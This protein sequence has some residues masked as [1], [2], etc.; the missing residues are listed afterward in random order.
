MRGIS[1][2][3]VALLGLLPSLSVQS[4]IGSR[5]LSNAKYPTRKLGGIE[6]IDT[7]IVREAAAFARLHSTDFVYNH[8]IRGWL[9]GV[10]VLNHNHTLKATVDIE[11][12]AVACLLHDL[13]WDQTPHSPFISPDRR[14]EVD[15]AIA[16]RNFI[17]S[18]RH[19][20]KDWDDA[21]IQLVWDSIAL[22]TAA[23]IFNYKEPTVAVTGV[24]INM[25]FSAPNSG[26]TQEEQNHVRAAFPPTNFLE[27]VN[28][29]FIWLAETKP[30]TTYD[31][32]M[33]AWGDAFVPGFSAVGHRAF[34]EIAVPQK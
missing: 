9:Y 6:V 30:A 4:A 10:L 27:G 1:V 19:S 8:I 26:V 15:G 16:A 32:F 7:Q 20:K 5:G 18:H 21:R 24:G 31:T 34:D 3:K 13:G 28:Q 12:H 29:T 14:F 11:A 33:Q 2:L 25:D 17:N 22:H 23:S